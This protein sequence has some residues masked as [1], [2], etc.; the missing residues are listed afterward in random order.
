MSRGVQPHGRFRSCRRLGARATV[1]DLPQ[2]T[3]VAREYAAKFAREYAAK[4]GVADRFEYMEGNLHQV[5]LG[6]GDYDLITLGHVIH[7][8]GREDGVKLIERC[9]RA[10]VSAE[11]C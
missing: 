3:P 4:F 11:C 5:D 10:L 2:V 9:F 8:E 1:L 7:S 6:D